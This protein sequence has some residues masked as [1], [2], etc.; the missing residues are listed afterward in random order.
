[1]PPEHILQHDCTPWRASS[2]QAATLYAKGV[3]LWRKAD[4]HDIERQLAAYTTE[5]L[6]TVRSIDGAKL[7]IA[8]PMFEKE[9]PIW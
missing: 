1:M 9:L 6:F 4:L 7:A 3:K 8:N 5:R 2:Q